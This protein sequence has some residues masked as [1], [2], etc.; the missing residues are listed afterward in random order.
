MPFLCLF[1]ELLAIFLKTKVTHFSHEKLLK[2]KVFAL[3]P[4]PSR[5]AE[6]FQFHQEIFWGSIFLEKKKK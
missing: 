2:G 3:S 5:G 4:S 6:L 1:F